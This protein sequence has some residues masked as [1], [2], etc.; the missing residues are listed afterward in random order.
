[1]N[2]AAKK[3]TQIYQQ[4]PKAEQETLFS[5]AEFLLSRVEDSSQSAVIPE[6]DLI[7][8]PEQETVIGAVK[9]LSKSYP[10]LDKST[11]LNET[12]ALVTANLVQGRDRAEVIDELETVFADAY[13]AFIDKKQAQ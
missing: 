7:P 6:P 5:F 10:M 12:S 3:L 1:M 4:L 11:L 13:Q 9:R 8:R 2:P